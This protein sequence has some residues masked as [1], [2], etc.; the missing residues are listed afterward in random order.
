MINN[1]DNIPDKLETARLILRR[2]EPGD[3]KLV[4]EAILETW[5]ELYKY[6]PWA[7]K[8][9]D[10][11]AEKVEENLRQQRSQYDARSAFFMATFDR[12]SGRFLGTVELYDV[13]WENSSMK[14]GYWFRK[15]AMGN[16]YASEAEI[17]LIDFAVKGL[18]A[19]KIEAWRQ[20]DNEASGR[21][22]LKAGFKEVSVERDVLDPKT[23]SVFNKCN[24]VLLVP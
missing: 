14:T 21:I 4:S 24:Y 13:D 17:A 3:G 16:G 12:F 15:S 11:T 22:L 8:R 5:E 9:E 20:S 19:K 23:G 18:G 6:A 2:T 7:Q 10:Y 1:R